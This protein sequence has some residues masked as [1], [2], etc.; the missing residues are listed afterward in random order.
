MTEFK[1]VISDPKTG[2]S[3]QKEVKD[4]NARPFLGQKIGIKFKG[5]LLDLPGYEFEIRGGSDNAG[6]PMRKDVKGT[7][8]AR[9]LAVRGVGIRKKKIGGR[10]SKKSA[11]GMR[12]RKTIASN[13]IQE[14]TAQIN[15]VIIKYGSEPLFEKPKTEG[16]KL[17]SKEEKTDV[18][19]QKED[20]S[21][22]EKLN[23]E[24]KVEKK[25][26]DKKS[27]PKKEIK[28]EHKKIKK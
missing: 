2:K 20:K 7:R 4:D 5:E 19:S 17:E 9:V 15:C 14:N 21:N 18:K 27:E 8:R 24:T 10:R 6:F 16:K 11:K 13:V 22:K 25:P 12:Q 1:I 28:E 26:E 23:T 3:I